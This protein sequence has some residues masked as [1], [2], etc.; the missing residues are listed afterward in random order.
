MEKLYEYSVCASSV[1]GGG[2]TAGDEK[3]EYRFGLDS[4]I[5]R[6]MV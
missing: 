1:S 3:Q 6:R 4:K 2:R 5:I